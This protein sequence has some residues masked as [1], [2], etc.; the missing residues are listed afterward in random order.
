MKFIET[1]EELSQVYG[2]PAAAATR[3]VA[4]Q[5]TPDYRTW[6]ERARFC[7][8]S[9]VGPEGADGSPRGDDGPVVRELDPGT[10]AL[11]DWHGNNRVDTLRNIVRDPRMAL[12][13]MVPGSNNVVR[14]NG[15]GRVTTDADLCAS[16]AR[17]GKQPRSVVVMQIDEIYFQ[18]ARAVMRAGLW[19]GRDESE[20]LP[21]P[22]QILA[23][24]T[25]G[26]VGGERYDREWPERAAK[27]LW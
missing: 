27:T 20:G 5:M 22:G 3:K 13:F 4:R 19:A 14:V 15:R 18:C 11:P 12:M 25:E 10:L 16:F 17:G 1:P 24:M 7:V 21:S 2:T 6:I 9:T 23:G 8:V 26:K